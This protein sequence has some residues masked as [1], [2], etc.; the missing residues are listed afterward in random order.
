MIIYF[1]LKLMKPKTN[2]VTIFCTAIMTKQNR[3]MKCIKRNYF[4]EF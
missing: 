1:Q 4:Q 2:V 3:E